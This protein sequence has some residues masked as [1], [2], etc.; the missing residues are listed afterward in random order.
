ME[1]KICGETD[2]N[3]FYV[4]NKAKCKKCCSTRATDRY[5]A[6][7]DVD[8]QHYKDNVKDWNNKNIFRVRYLV[9]KH[10]ANKKNIIF[11]I[12]ENDL[13]DLW[14][15]QNGRCYYSNLSMDLAQ[16]DATYSVSIER[17]NSSIGYIKD[18]V[19]LCCSGINRMKNKLDTITFLT[20]ITAIYEHQRL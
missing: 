13:R 8:K 6:L 14:D 19:V 4:T 2:E 1:C 20:L 11:D 3:N 10:R 7:S 18:N 12:T 9:G 16:D 5:H 15:V 17:K